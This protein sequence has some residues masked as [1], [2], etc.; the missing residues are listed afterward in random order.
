VA[1]EVERD[2]FRAAI[3][4]ATRA[5]AAADG[6]VV[7]SSVDDEEGRR[8]TMVVRVPS[9]SFEDVLA[10]LRELGTVQRESVSGEDVSQE[11]VDLEARLRNAR[12][13]EAVYLRLFDAATTI[14]ETIRIQQELEGVQLQI[15][16]I[17]GR[18]RYLRDRTALGT[19][20]LDLVEA[21]AAADEG[22]FRGAWEQA[23]AMIKGFVAGLISALG[24]LVPM[25]MLALV[26]LGVWRG[27]RRRRPATPEPAA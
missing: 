2:G 8:G 21:G 27:I 10:N 13:Q 18:L 5:V 26:G 3:G 23:V 9:E 20:S 11:F 15:E 19:I 16:E 7:S 22:L 4:R 6:F 24:V 12:T 25:A 17:E 1:I 14:R